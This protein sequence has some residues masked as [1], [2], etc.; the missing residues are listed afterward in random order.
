VNPER[1]V[2]KDH[3]GRPGTSVWITAA[4]LADMPGAALFISAGFVTREDD[5]CVWLSSSITADD[6]RDAMGEPELILK[7][8]IVSRHPL[9][10][11]RQGGELV[12]GSWDVA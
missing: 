7:A 6:T 4:E 9:V 8:C 5:E 1:I 12:T 2:W 10:T 11:L 3:V